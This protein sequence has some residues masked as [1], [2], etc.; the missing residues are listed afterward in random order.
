MKRLATV[1]HRRSVTFATLA[2]VV[3]LAALARVFHFSMLAHQHG[4]AFVQ[5]TLAVCFIAFIVCTLVLANLV[6]DVRRG[7]SPGRCSL[8]AV[9]MLAAFAGPVMLAFTLFSYYLR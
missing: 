7:Y 9:I 1:F 2:L 4:G 6:L 5:E 8:A 3:G